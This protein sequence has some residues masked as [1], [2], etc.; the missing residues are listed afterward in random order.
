M[1]LHNK[2]Q[3]QS[4][5]FLIIWFDFLLLVIWIRNIG[6]LTKKCLKN[7]MGFCFSHTSRACEIWT[8]PIV[9]NFIHIF[10]FFYLP[11]AVWRLFQRCALPVASIRIQALDTPSCDTVMIMAP[12]NYA[13]RSLGLRN[14]IV[15]SKRVSQP[16][17][18]EVNM[19]FLGTVVRKD[20]LC[21]RMFDFVIH[22][23]VDLYFG[24]FIIWNWSTEAHMILQVFASRSC[25][26]NSIDDEDMSF[27]AEWA[28]KLAYFYDWMQIFCKYFEE[29]F[30]PE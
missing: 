10:Y 1:P 23:R 2:P 29:S 19:R 5:P 24:I 13:E 27:I 17:L 28:K 14:K 7:I 8:V 9:S 11:K 6:R 21:I 26:Q 12:R 30:K 20:C 16:V 25:K 22:P 4:W 18:Y 15:V 3:M